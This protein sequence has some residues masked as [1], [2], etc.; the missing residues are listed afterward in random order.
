MDGIGV[1]SFFLG[2]RIDHA[3]QVAK[4]TFGIFHF[5]NQGHLIHQYLHADRFLQLN[6]L[7]PEVLD[8]ILLLPSQIPEHTRDSPWHGRLD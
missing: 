3:Y 6:D 1:T 2:H 4:V 5:A 7:L 8:V